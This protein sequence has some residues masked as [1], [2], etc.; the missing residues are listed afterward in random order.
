MNPTLHIQEVTVKFGGLT[1]V[2]QVE[3]EL[4]RGS[5]MGLIGPNGSGKTTLLNT[6]SGLYKP[7]SGSI[8]FEGKKIEDMHPHKIAS[9]GIARTFQNNQ[10]FKSMTVL[11][12]VMVGQHHRMN[13]NLAYSIFGGGGAAKEEAEARK[14]S[15]EVLEIVGLGNE[16]SEMAENLPYGKQKLLEIARALASRPQLLLLDEPAAGMNPQEKVELGAIIRKTNQLGISILMVEHDMK[17]IMG[18][19]SK[20]VVLNF[21]KKISEGSANK[22]AKDPEVISAYLGKDDILAKS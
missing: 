11:E 14:Y 7:V 17:M 22:V 15:Q 19:C 1:A 18:L 8:L 2:N 3:F 4:E 21:G 12:N 9:L 13:T 20:I 6:I 10:I 5:L 16:S